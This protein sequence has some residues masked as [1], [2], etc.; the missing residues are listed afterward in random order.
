MAN[1][2]STSQPKDRLLLIDEDRM[3]CELLQYK[4]QTEGFVVDICHSGTE[5]LGKLTPDYNLLLIDLME[6][7]EMDG[8]Q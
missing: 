6:S 1:E 7:K 5:A 2:I 3:S 4:F 8:F